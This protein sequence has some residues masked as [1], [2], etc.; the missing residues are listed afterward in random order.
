ME[1]R[2]TRYRDRETQFIFFLTRRPLFR[3]R[4]RVF[5][6]AYKLRNTIYIRTHMYKSNK[7]GTDPEV[8]GVCEPPAD[9]RVAFTQN[10]NT[11]LRDCS[12][13]S[14]SRERRAEVQSTFTPLVIK[15]LHQL[16]LVSRRY[17]P[18]PLFVLAL[19]REFPV[20]IILAIPQ[21]ALGEP[22]S[23]PSLPRGNLRI[24]SFNPQQGIILIAGIRRE[25]CRSN[26]LFPLRASLTAN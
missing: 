18:S 15:C 11:P 1:S 20:L 16:Q 14:K 17:R 6:K 24:K 19:F 3:R 9:L 13:M 21:R 12:T 23:S 2:G 7:R 22:S 4:E 5:G 26:R 25:E 8:T 10:A